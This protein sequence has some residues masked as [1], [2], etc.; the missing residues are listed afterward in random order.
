MVADLLKALQ[1]RNGRS[2]GGTC[3]CLLWL[4]VGALAQGPLAAVAQPTV[5]VVADSRIDIES[6]RTP[7]SVRI[8]GR[9]LDDMDAPLSATS[10]ELR[11]RSGGLPQ[12]LVRSLESDAEGN[13]GTELSLPIGTYEVQ[14]RYRG[15][16]LRRGVTQTQALDLTRAQVR[17]RFVSP[18]TR[19]IDLDDDHVEVVVAASSAEGASDLPLMLS[20]G[21]GQPLARG[22]TDAEGR[23]WAQVPTSA[24]GGDARA[25]LIATTRADARRAAG[26]ASLDVIGRRRPRL[27]LAASAEPRAQQLQ[28]EGRLL[29]RTGPLAR[30]AI[31]LRLNGQRLATLPTDVQGHFRHTQQL[32]AD[33]LPEDGR[34]RIDARFESDAPW[35]TSSRAKPVELTMLPPEPAN[36]TWLALPLLLCGVGLWWLARRARRLEPEPLRTPPP[37]PLP[38]VRVGQAQRLSLHTHQ[39]VGGWV[40]D[41]ATGQPIPGA[42]VVLL[43]PD[44]RPLQ[45]LADSQGRFAAQAL[46]AGN[47]RLQARTEQHVPVETQLTIPHRGEWNQMDIRLESL[48]ARALRPFRPVAL[49]LLRHDGRLFDVLTPREALARYGYSAPAGTG[50][51]SPPAAQPDRDGRQAFPAARPAPDAA[52]QAAVGGEANIRGARDRARTTTQALN[53]LAQRVE[54][55][56]YGPQTPS[57]DEIAH[58]D[59]DAEG[60]LDQLQRGH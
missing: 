30:R 15:D 18:T 21:D 9:L 10:I 51:D 8:K 40:R 3:R 19:L 6:H 49:E 20:D 14:A 39:G 23:F 42:Q 54:R 41:L 29:T 46:A 26:R 43:G 58:I 1:W 17:L 7:G 16:S 32:E 44:S 22:S 37:R 48:R 56:A 36:A 47:H 57:M 35:L 31:E 24:I 60:A 28:I 34:L 53:Q 59:A 13:F 55:A 38:G 12:D 5:Q 50:A 52:G 27:E 4:L 33:E 45:V 11:I 2:V 25:R